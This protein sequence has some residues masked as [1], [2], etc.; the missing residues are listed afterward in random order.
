VLRNRGA[1]GSSE[2]LN[3]VYV[4]K[5]G[6]LGLSLTTTGA[7]R[8]FRTHHYELKE[9]EQYGIPS[10]SRVD[11]VVHSD[12]DSG[13]L[14]SP[15]SS[16]SRFLLG[17]R[18]EIIDSGVDSDVVSRGGTTILFRFSVDSGNRI[19]SESISESPQNRR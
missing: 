15:A 18:I 16:R 8:T 7:L 14:R 1:A 17:P 6:V 4:L 9:I 12:F 13:P 10:R 5:Q 19:G 3:T 2:Y 11:S